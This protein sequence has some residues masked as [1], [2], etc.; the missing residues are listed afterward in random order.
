M[1]GVSTIKYRIAFGIVAIPEMY[2]R[3]QYALITSTQPHQVGPTLL[4]LL[5]LRE[6][7]IVA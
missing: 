4:Q 7:L 3:H 1:H 6:V 2:M 5:Q